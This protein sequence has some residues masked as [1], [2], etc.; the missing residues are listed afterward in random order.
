MTSREQLVAWFLTSFFACFLLFYF[1]IKLIKHVRLKRSE[2]GDHLI[3]ETQLPI[4]S[5]NF[6]YT[7][8]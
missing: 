8:E 2:S 3:V 5:P 1:L 7:H 6:S 4:E